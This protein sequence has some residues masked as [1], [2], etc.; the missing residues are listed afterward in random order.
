MFVALCGSLALLARF[1]AAAL[2]PARLLSRRLIR[3]ARLILVRHGFSFHGN[4]RPTARS[5]GSFLTKKKCGW[6]CRNHV[7]LTYSG[8][9]FLIDVLARQ[10]LRRVGPRLLRRDTAR[11][12][13]EFRDHHTNTQ[14]PLN[15]QAGTCVWKQPLTTRAIDS[16]LNKQGNFLDVECKP[17]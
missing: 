10:R 17:E 4:T 15:E 6:Q 14:P 11:K 2:L 1:L 12:C 13:L 8:F 7:S 9:G 3:L 16:L 5:S